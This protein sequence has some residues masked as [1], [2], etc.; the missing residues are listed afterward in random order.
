MEISKNT[1]STNK[2]E[3]RGDVTREQLSNIDLASTLVV[4]RSLAKANGKNGIERIHAAPK[5]DPYKGY[6]DS[7]K[8]KVLRGGG[9]T[10]M[11]ALPV[12][13]NH[14]LKGGYVGVKH[15]TNIRKMGG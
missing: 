11:A 10:H 5:K 15:G 4:P 1:P 3:N 2:I 9:D 14:A 12:F 6:F 8:V 13:R 7:A